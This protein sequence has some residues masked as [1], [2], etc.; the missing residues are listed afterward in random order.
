MLPS[1]TS[2]QAALAAALFAFAPTVDAA[3]SS[4]TYADHA[5]Q[6]IQSL[7]SDFY[8]VKTGIW[9]DAWWNSANALTTLAD[10]AKL[11]LNDANKLNVGGY[12]RNTF[13]QAQKTTVQTSKSLAK[14]GMVSSVYCLDSSSGCMAKREFLGKRGFNDFVNEFYDDEGW[15]ALALIHSYD[16]TGDQEYLNAA[17][18][19]FNDMKTGAGT[20]CGG[21]IFWSKDRKYVNAI[22]NELY[23]SVAASLANRISQDKSYLDIAKS[24]WEWFEKSGMINDKSLINDGLDGNCKNNGL[25]T[26]SYNQGV[27]LGGLTE[28]AKAT[29]DVSYIEKAVPIAKAAINALQNDQGIL[30]ETD[31]CELRSGSCGK[32]GQQFKGVFIRNLRY[33]YEEAP[34]TDFSDF[35]TR[36]ADSIWAQDRDGSKL[37]VSWPGPYTAHTGP[38][39]S[40]ALDALVAAIA[41]TQ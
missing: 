12:I 17:V 24:Q 2:W 39:Q 6:A 22:A 1:T 7:N 40:S 25:Q 34:D 35:I 23:L 28:L 41:V 13:N 16:V 15:W 9:D 37:G 20:P 11:R 36:N 5:S 27:I 3:E 29:R 31:K 26:W 18:D 10:F 14:N 21:G 19:I 32:D 38:S 30:V 33:L 8:N 4:Q